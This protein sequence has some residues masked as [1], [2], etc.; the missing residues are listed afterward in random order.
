M[1]RMRYLAVAVALV[2]MLTA[3]G[4][5][6]PDATASPTPLVFDSQLACQGLLPQE[7][8]AQFGESNVALTANREY[9][10]SEEGGRT[11]GYGTAE[12]QVLLGFTLELDRD[13]SEFNDL[14]NSARQ[15]GRFKELTGLGQQAYTVWPQYMAVRQGTWTLTATYGGGET[16]D[17]AGRQRATEA[18]I[19]TYVSRLRG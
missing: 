12:Q 3:C 13:G 5:D 16:V 10:E 18:L 4:G 7:V 14:L 11:C 1:G 8:G 6:K 17:H 9:Q 15:D 2:L 19:R